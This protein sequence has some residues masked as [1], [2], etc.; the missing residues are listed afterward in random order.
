MVIIEPRTASHFPGETAF[1]NCRDDEVFKVVLM[2]SQDQQQYLV[3]ETEGGRVL[4]SGSNRGHPAWFAP[5]SRD[6]IPGFLD[7]EENSDSLVERWAVVPDRGLAITELTDMAFC[8]PRLAFE[9]A[10]AAGRESALGSNSGRM[11]QPPSI[12]E[13][14]AALAGMDPL[15]WDDL[16]D[17]ERHRDHG[18]LRRVVHNV[19]PAEMCDALVE[20]INSNANL[21][22]NDFQGINDDKEFWM[23]ARVKTQSEELA[24]LVFRRMAPAVADLIIKVDNVDLAQQH[25]VVQG[26][27]A[28]SSAARCPEALQIGAGGVWRPHGFNHTMRFAKYY[29]GGCFRKHIDAMYQGSVY[30]WTEQGLVEHEDLQMEMPPLAGARVAEAQLAR[31]GENGVD[32]D[33]L[34]REGIVRRA[35]VRTLF[36]CLFYLNDCEGGETN[37]MSVPARFSDFQKIATPANAP[38]SPGDAEFLTGVKP[39]RGSALLFF[40]PGLV[41]DGA[42]VDAGSEKYFMRTDLIFARDPEP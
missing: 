6:L 14:R 8:N 11:A 37:F 26:I 2:N 39:R 23:S 21:A 24:D 32:V 18:E 12:G 17:V 1:V 15:D 4:V 29:S 7:P 36:S 10:R 34:I 38:V 3:V 27:E 31:W 30:V 19:F 28:Q 35:A 16:T 20:W 42:E 40:Q 5:A 22:M 25:L 13:F 9:K 41:H 33:R